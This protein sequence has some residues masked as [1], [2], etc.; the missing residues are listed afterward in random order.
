MHCIKNTSL[1]LGIL[2]LAAC[3]ATGFKGTNRVV[4]SEPLPVA[5]DYT[6]VA[7]GM[8]ETVDGGQVQMATIDRLKVVFQAG[9][10][11]IVGTDTSTVRQ[12]VDLYFVLDTTASMTEVMRAVKDGIKGLVS[13][14]RRSGLDLNV[15]LVG[16][17]DSFASVDAR[18]YRL[19]SNYTGFK[20]SFQAS[21]PQ[22]MTT[23][24]R[25]QF[26]VHDGRS[27]CLNQV[28]G[29]APSRQLF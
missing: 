18:T 19:S 5:R 13:E 2:A 16:F 11:R 14:L 9:D 4:M 24:L 26:M 23:T 6:L 8:D 10:R 3:N 1:V 28:P 17:V 7:M 20:I 15:G 21:N 29:K 25:Q 27:N 12:A 22:A